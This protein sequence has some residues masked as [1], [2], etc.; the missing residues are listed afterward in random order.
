MDLSPPFF[1]LL[2]MLKAFRFQLVL[3]CQVTK[4]ALMWRAGW[5]NGLRSLWEA[6][7]LCPYLKALAPGYGGSWYNEASVQQGQR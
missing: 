1:H 6:H 7:L 4:D 3:L 5:V 2:G